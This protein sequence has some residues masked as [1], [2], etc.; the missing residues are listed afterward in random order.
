MQQRLYI[1][2]VGEALGASE[3]VRNSQVRCAEPDADVPRRGPREQSPYRARPILNLGNIARIDLFD[4]CG[5]TGNSRYFGAP[6]CGHSGCSWRPGDLASFQLP[7]D[8]SHVQGSL[9]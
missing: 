2:L 3:P 6:R 4:T 8:I 1:S 7:P 5:M 9:L